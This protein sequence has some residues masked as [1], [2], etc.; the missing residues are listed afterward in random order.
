[1]MNSVGSLLSILGGSFTGSLSRRRDRRTDDT[2]L[3]WETHGEYGGFG[4]SEYFGEYPWCTHVPIIFVHG[5]GRDAS[6]WVPAMESLQ[7]QSGVSGDSLW[8]ITFERESSTHEEMAEQLE[9]FVTEVLAYTNQTQVSLVGHS[10]GVTGIRYW[11]AKYDRYDDIDTFVGLAGANHGL[12]AARIGDWLGMGLGKSRPSPFLNP[13]KMD[14]PEH[15]LVQLNENETPAGVDWYTIR[16]TNDRCF[17]RLPRS[18]ELEG[19]IENKV[20]HTSHDGLRTHPETLAALNKWV[21]TE[22]RSMAGV[23]R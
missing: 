4:G 9:A 2:D 14:D 13:A 11:A 8:A 10:L 21:P 16:A 22:S 17:L 20:I 1:M 6:D 5:N 18:P 3:S 12:Y 7:K 23:T 15:P 19:A